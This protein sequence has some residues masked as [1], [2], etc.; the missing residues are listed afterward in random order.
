MAFVIVHYFFGN[1]KPYTGTPV[2]G[3]SMEA[4]KYIKDPL[5][6]FLLKPYPIVLKHW[7]LANR[8]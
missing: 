8:H 3:I 4:G 5:C 1:G 7:K 6:V 2:L